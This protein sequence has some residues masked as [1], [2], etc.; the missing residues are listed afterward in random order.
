[1]SSSIEQVTRQKIGNGK[2]LHD[3]GWNI[4]TNIAGYIA[5]CCSFSDI[6]VCGL[7]HK[8]H[9][10]WALLCID[11]LARQFS[12]SYRF[13][14]FRLSPSLLHALGCVQYRN[15]GKRLL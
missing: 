2:D 11:V 4:R 13:K 12:F 14:I 7:N 9:R 6:N 15:V 8:Y 5:D 3:R 1:M 10:Q